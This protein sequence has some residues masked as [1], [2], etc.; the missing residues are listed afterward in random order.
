MPT[1]SLI[2]YSNGY[3]KA[4]GNLWQY[5]REEPNDGVTDFKPIKFR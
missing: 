3:L 4:P 2:E 5:R 1:Y